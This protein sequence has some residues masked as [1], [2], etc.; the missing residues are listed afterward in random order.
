MTLRTSE[1]AL[2]LEL[3][4]RSPISGEVLDLAGYPLPNVM[5]QARPV[6]D[7]RGQ[8]FEGLLA[9]FYTE[10]SANWPDPAAPVASA[11]PG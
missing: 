7:V 2:E 5:V 1:E 6:S 3:L 11:A 8:R 4:D 10:P 9:E